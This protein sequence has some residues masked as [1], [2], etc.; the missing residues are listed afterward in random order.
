MELDLASYRESQ[1]Q[2][3]IDG[4]VVFG[5][6][7]KPGDQAVT[8]MISRKMP[9]KIRGVTFAAMCG[10]SADAADLGVAV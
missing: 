9:D 4:V 3:K 1:P 6:D 5:A 10:M 8:A 7:M 2:I